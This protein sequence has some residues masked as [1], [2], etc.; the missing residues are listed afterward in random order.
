MTH[1]WIPVD[2]VELE[3]SKDCVCGPTQ[4]AN[5]WVHHPI[6]RRPSLGRWASLR[7]VLWNHRHGWNCEDA[8]LGCW[9]ARLFDGQRARRPLNAEPP[10]S[11]EAQAQP[12]RQ[13]NG[14]RDVRP[15]NGWARAEP[16]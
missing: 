3:R 16:H 7:V 10:S 5:D 14:P 4:R 13:G 12:H 9:F 1:H 2:V 8:G 11:V 15:I 6:D